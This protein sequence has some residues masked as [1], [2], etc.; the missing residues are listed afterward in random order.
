MVQEVDY[1][2]LQNNLILKSLQYAFRDRKN[3]KRDIRALWISRIN[4]AQEILEYLILSL[5]MDLIKKDIV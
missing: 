1:I 2:K 4:A 5:L 3:K